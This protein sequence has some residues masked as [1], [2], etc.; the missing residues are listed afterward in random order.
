MTAT[1]LYQYIF[2]EL[3]PPGAPAHQT[4]GI[5]PLRPDNNGEFI[6]H[7]PAHPKNTIPD[8]PLDDANNPWLGLRAYAEQHAPL[9]FGREKVV[10]DL[11]DRALDPER[12]RFLAV[13]GASGTG[14]SS[15]V[16]AGLI[17]MLSAPPEKEKERIGNWT[18]VSCER[19]HSSPIRQLDDMIEQLDAL[20]GDQRKLC[21]IDQFEE[22]Y[23]RCRDEAVR[24]DFLNRL[25]ELVDNN[26][27]VFVV[28]TLRSDFEP[29]PASCEALQSLWSQGRYLVPALTVEEFRDC[30]IGPA[31]VKAIYFEPDEL[32]G[33]LLDE[34]MSMPGALPMLSFALAEM[35]RRAEVRRRETG[36]TDRALTRADYEAT[37]GVVGALHRRASTLYDNSDAATQQSIKRV[38]LRMLSQDGARLTRR[39]IGLSE[40][41]YADSEEQ[42]RVK[43]LVDAYVNARLLVVDGEEIEPA[44]DTLVVAWDRLL[45][46][47]SDAGPQTLIRSIWRAAS[48]WHKNSRDKGLLWDDDPRLAVAL[49]RQEPLNKLEREFV[50]ASE[51]RRKTKRNSRIWIAAAV[52]TVILFGGTFALK[53]MSDAQ[54]ARLTRDQVYLNIMERGDFFRL[55][56][57]L[58]ENAQAGVVDTPFENWRWLVQQDEG[59][60]VVAQSFGAGRVMAIGHEALLTHVDGYGE[61]LFV[62]LALDWLDGE[63]GDLIVFSDGHNEALALYHAQGFQELMARLPE[64]GY[65][66]ELQQELDDLEQV[67]VL[68]VGNAW[69]DFTAEEI[70]KVVQF[71]DGGGGLLAAGLGWSWIAN[72]DHGEEDPERALLQ[73]PMNQLMAP[74]GLRWSQDVIWTRN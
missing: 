17:P 4:P 2:E 51:K 34:V 65:V 52:A 64:Q 26:P 44:H 58:G 50:N 14:K 21:F 36:A 49:T 38:F 8:P 6:F 35:Y 10:A 3:V 68:V 5:W 57:V 22:L 60:L 70:D 67:A 20:A 31:Q 66:V 61:S 47:L 12:T 9:Y 74:F 53:T 54:T 24:A 11:L 28:L 45:D 1:E 59:P 15:V 7:S 19:L 48:D 63:N 72:A 29:R 71:V 62:E 43:S 39:R 69:A 33:D 13:V 23:T 55:E 56:D 25:R 46:W 18:V 27:T 16:K 42:G 30:I 41:E 37:G 32:V 40:L 73:Y